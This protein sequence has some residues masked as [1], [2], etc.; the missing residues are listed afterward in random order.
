MAK[1]SADEKILSY[2]DVVLR[3]SDLDI[4]NGPCFVNDRIIEFYFSYL[5]ACNP[6]EDILLVPPSIAFWI[7]NCPDIGCLKDFVEPLN[8]STK[9]LVL[10][11]VNNND[12]VTEVEGGSHWSLLAFERD[13]TVF[14]HHDSYGGI[15]QRHAKRLCEVVAPYMNISNT[16]SDEL[17]HE[18]ASTPQQVNTYDCGLYVIAIARAICRWYSEGQ[19]DVGLLWF[20]TLK[21]QVTPYT[22]S[23]MRN[24]ILEL[25]RSLKASK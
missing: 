17:Y 8:L 9:K 21:E 7:T 2:N 22:V 14:V 24:E 6:S 4:L 23:K 1:A 10:F 15:N 16:T 12:D 3:R 13:I 18:C 20:S 19:E 5:S 11:P 25:I